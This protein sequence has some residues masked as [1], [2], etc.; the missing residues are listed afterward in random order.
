MLKEG[1]KADRSNKTHDSKTV[2][3]PLQN[4]TSLRLLAKEDIKL[5]YACKSVPMLVKFYK[6]LCIWPHC[7]TTFIRPHIKHQRTLNIKFRKHCH[8]HKRQW[9]PPINYDTLNELSIDYIFKSIQLRHDL[10]F[11]QNL[12]FRPNLDGPSGREKRKRADRFW[13]R[14]EYAFTTKSFAFLRPIIQEMCRI[15]VSLMHPFHHHRV[16]WFWPKS[17]TR[18]DVHDMLDADLII[19]QLEFNGKIGNQ[20]VLWLKFIFDSILREST[21][22]HTMC[23]YFD[24]GHYAKALRQCFTIMEKIKLVSIYSKMYR[25]KYLKFVFIRVVLIAYWDSIVLI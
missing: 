11:D 13:K 17:I 25:D 15:L 24:Q 7:W 8:H 4:M 21:S 23:M 9:R 5:P 19:Q 12:N 3:V 16:P 22:T 10:V 2:T 14:V 1:Y 20:R 18:R 6:N